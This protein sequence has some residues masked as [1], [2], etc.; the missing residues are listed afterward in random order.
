MGSKLTASARSELLV[1]IMLP[2]PRLVR[3]V[4]MLTNQRLIYNA[5][6]ALSKEQ[7]GR[8]FVGTCIEAQRGQKSDV[9]IWTL[10]YI[11]RTLIYF[12]GPI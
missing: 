6:L 9:V 3:Q 7:N 2:E 4:V 1:L 12:L 10:I 8:E 11:I 5:G